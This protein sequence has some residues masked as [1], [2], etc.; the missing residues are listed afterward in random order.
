MTQASAINFISFGSAA[1]E[2]VIRGN[3]I[4][5]IGGN[6]ASV[7]GIDNGNAPFTIDVIGNR[8]SG[9]QFNSGINLFQFGG[10]SVA[11]HIANNAV[12]G[13]VNVAGA[14]GAIVADVSQGIGLLTIVNNSVAFNERDWR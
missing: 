9:S 12:S 7:I 3:V 5:Q 8:I 13:Q 10:G 6:Q 11:G 1:K 2:G 4:E 14:S